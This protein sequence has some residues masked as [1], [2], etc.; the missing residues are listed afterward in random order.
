MLKTNYHTHYSICD[1]KG[2]AE[3][4]V[5][6]AL[7]KGFT[8]LG[9][10][11]HAPVPFEN[12]TNMNQEDLPKYLK[13][14]QTLKSQYQGK[15]EIYL[16]LEIDHIHEHPEPQKQ[17]IALPELDYSIGSF[18]CMW[19]PKRKEYREIDSTPEIFRAILDEDFGGNIRQ[20]VERYYQYLA[21]LLE[22]LQPTILGHFDLIKKNNPDTLYFKETE[23]WY[24]QAVRD[25][26]PY[27]RKYEPIVEVN[28]GGIARG[29][30]KEVYPSPWI[31]YELRKEDIPIMINTDAHTPD[32]LDAF[33]EEASYIVKDVGY[34]KV[35]NLTSK[36]WIAQP[37]D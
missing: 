26:L 23:P 5:V 2:E 11:S 28:T 4:Y 20:F 24:Q 18:H 31:L 13:T 36:G 14:I 30:T 1:G 6:A 7:Q 17:L 29:K 10:S 32:L 27:I 9:F 12:P 22:T 33:M 35:W 8:A 3:E 21:E 25:M 16:G 34:R 19:S 37:L 15:L